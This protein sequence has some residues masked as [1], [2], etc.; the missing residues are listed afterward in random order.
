LKKPVLGHTIAQG[1]R[2]ILIA[3]GEYV[4]HSIGIPNDLNLIIQPGD[5]YLPIVV[6]EGGSEIPVNPH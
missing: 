5:N 1:E 3:P 4:W 2:Y 6:G